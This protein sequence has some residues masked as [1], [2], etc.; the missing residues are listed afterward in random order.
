MKYLVNMTRKNGKSKTILLEAHS[1][2]DAE[3]KAL[4]QFPNF[5]IGRITASHSEVDFFNTIKGMKNE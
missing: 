2:K 5:V 4:K 1:T 3:E